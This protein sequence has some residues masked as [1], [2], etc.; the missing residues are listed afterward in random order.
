MGLWVK[1][2]VVGEGGGEGEGGEEAVQAH[3]LLV[4]RHAPQQIGNLE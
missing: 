2:G 4:L 1:V 3:V